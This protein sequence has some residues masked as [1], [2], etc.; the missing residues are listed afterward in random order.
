M[1]DWL[2]GL[3]IFLVLAAVVIWLLPGGIFQWIGIGTVVVLL[4]GAVTKKTL[5]K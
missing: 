5:G 2:L 4:L 1:S 3:I